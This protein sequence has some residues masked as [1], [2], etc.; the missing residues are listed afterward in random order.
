MFIPDLINLIVN[1]YS[2]P[3][4]SD[5]LVINFTQIQVLG[6]ALYTYGAILLITLSVI[7]LL[8]MVATITIS[9]S[10]KEKK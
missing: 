7:L 4:F 3:S 6:H 1:A 10:N 9:R 8:A 5:V 2:N